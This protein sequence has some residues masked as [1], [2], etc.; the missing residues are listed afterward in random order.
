MIDPVTAIA[1][2]TKAYAMVRGMVEAGRSVEDTMGQIASWYGHA[3]DVLYQEQKANKVSPFRKV[4]FSKSVEAEAIKAFA[5]KKKIQEQQREILLM[6]RYA[7]GD[8]G[9][10]EFRELKRKIVQERQDT[11]YR[12]Q[13]LKENMLLTLFGVVF[14]IITFGLVSA[15]VREIKG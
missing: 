6:I 5:R 13:E 10:R 4:V 14:S 9:L 15:V 8:D 11:V 3:S 2:A 1:G 7:Y 12:Q